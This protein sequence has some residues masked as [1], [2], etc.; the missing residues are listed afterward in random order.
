MAISGSVYIHVTDHTNRSIEGALVSA[1]D[2]SAYTDEKG[3]ALLEIP[4]G[5]EIKVEARGYEGQVRFVERKEASRTQLFTLGR[6]G[7]PYYYRGKVKVPFEPL[8]GTIGVLAKAEN[9]RDK[10]KDAKNNIADTAKRVL[11]IKAF[12]SREQQAQRGAEQFVALHRI[13]MGGHISVARH[14]DIVAFD[15]KGLAVFRRKCCGAA[16]RFANEDLVV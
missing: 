7:M 2:A 12:R 8:P 9:A 15:V 3:R 5:V 13:V 14:Y 6:A 11:D 4:A 1:G 10:K 16:F